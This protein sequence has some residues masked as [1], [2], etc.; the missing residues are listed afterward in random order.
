M[1]FAAATYLQHGSIL[2]EFLPHNNLHHRRIFH[3]HSV[4]GHHIW[5]ICPLSK[6][7]EKTKI[8][9]ETHQILLSCN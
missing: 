4:R 5:R 2:L 3:S 6:K 9:L 7:R 8:T 1:L